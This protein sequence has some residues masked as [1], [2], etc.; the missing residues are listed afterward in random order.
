VAERLVRATAPEARI[1]RLGL[2]TGDTTRAHTPP[3]EL[4]AQVVRG[5]HA[6]GRAPVG[7]RSAQLALDVT[8]LDRAVAALAALIAHAPPGT[9]HLASPAPLT[10][11][12]LLDALDEVRGTP[13]VREPEATWLAA[14][15]APDEPPDARVARLALSRL[16]LDAGEGLGAVSAHHDAWRTLDLFQA[17]GVR[18]DDARSRA[19]LG[20]A[21]IEPPTRA[22]VA[23]YVRA[24]LERDDAAGTGVLTEAAS[25][26]VE[27]S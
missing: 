3:A 23:Q 11:P 18:F 4:L 20:Y 12:A 17:T 15:P 22:L 9:Y 10:L 19:V 21:P 26:G 7:P 1:H 13:L 24:I 25:S 6:L 8:P 14:A 5:L 16:A 27:P 2:V